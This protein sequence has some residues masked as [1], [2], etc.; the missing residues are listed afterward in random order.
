MICELCGKETYSRFLNPNNRWVC[1]MCYVVPDTKQEI[2]ELLRSYINDS[3]R[4]DDRVLEAEKLL[5]DR[6]DS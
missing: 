3:G 1:E 6:W 2:L 5:S 4:P